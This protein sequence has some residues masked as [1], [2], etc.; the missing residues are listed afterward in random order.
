MVRSHAFGELDFGA[1]PSALKDGGWAPREVTIARR[2]FKLATLPTLAVVLCAVTGGVHRKRAHI[3]PERSA[4][5]AA[6]GPVRPLEARLAGASYAAYKTL[7]PD[8]AD[9][10]VISAQ[11]RKAG[12]KGSPEAVAD[13]GV[14]LLLKG[15]L[16]DSI[17]ALE[18]AVALDR[19]NARTES[20]LAA[21]YLARTPQVGFDDG[22]KALAHA[23]RAVHLDPSLPEA[24]FNHALALEGLSLLHDADASWRS[25]LQIDSTSSWAEEARLHGMGIA[26]A[27]A[28][29]EHR[30]DLLQLAATR[31]R[32]ALERAIVRDPQSAREFL[33]DE[34]LPQWA[35]LAEMKD[36]R[37]TP[38][39]A[40]MRELADILLQA[41]KDRLPIEAVEA[42]ERADNAASPGA[43]LQALA[44][45]HRQYS[46]GQSAL[47][48]GDI[49]KAAGLFAASRVAF[50]RGRSPFV[51]WAEFQ[52]GVCVYQ[53]ADYLGARA[54]LSPLLNAEPYPNLHA[55][56]LWILGLSEIVQ[57]DLD[58]SLSTYRRAL[59]LFRQS[60]ELRNAG[61]IENLIAEALR[62]LGRKDEA[63]RSLYAAVRA[64]AAMRDPRRRVAIL[65]E[66]ATTATAEGRPE[67][68]LLFHDEA[69]RGL[70]NGADRP[71]LVFALIKRAET[72][73]ALQR[74]AVAVADLEQARRILDHLTSD[75]VREA[76]IGDYLGHLGGILRAIDPERAVRSLSASAD[77]YRDSHYSLFL[78]ALLKERALS[79]EALGQQDLAERD[80]IEATEAAERALPTIEDDAAR[81]DYL[82]EITDLLD[83][84]V[85]LQLGRGRVEEAF[86]YEE[87]A[88]V[89]GLRPLKALTP[90]EIE[91]KLPQG[92]AVIG[93][94]AIRDL[95]LIWSVRRDGFAVA[96]SPLSV[97]DTAN[98]VARLRKAIGGEND[99]EFSTTSTALY[100]AIVGPV[101]GA[102]E[103]ATTIEFLPSQSLTKLPFVALQNPAT[104]HFLIEDHAVGIALSASSY[105]ASLANDRVKPRSKGDALVVGDPAFR[106]DLLQDLPRLP[107]AA[108][109]AK[110]I[111]ALY[112]KSTLLLGQQA[113]KKAFLAAAGQYEIV[114]FA[115]H[116]I[117]NLAAPLRSG[118]VFASSSREDTG[119]LTAA[120]LYDADFP[121]T[122][123]IVLSGCGTALGPIEESD[124]FADFAR[125]LFATGVPSVVASL[126]GVNDKESVDL[127]THFHARL[128]GGDDPLK[129]LRQAQLQMLGDLGRGATAVRRWAAFE[130]ISGGWSSGG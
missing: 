72:E 49:R 71:A 81:L 98:L 60:G 44:A 50:S 101:E 63:S 54:R 107:E 62:H 96:A 64:L 90:A 21:A 22:V 43:Q 2:V 109:E 61:A 102:L 92:V 16:D 70:A 126:W 79:Y 59:L 95:L 29:L 113:T 69:I 111:A 86:K 40:S 118:L 82:G 56:A 5:F 27:A 67:V 123:V 23:A 129:A 3:S 48:A 112:P 15:K 28:A 55:R 24:R 127:M 124:G 36:A 83:E 76:F 53:E 117:T 7:P 114:H 8:L 58:A 12:E 115:G 84:M 41:E 34:A 1:I 30:P 68:A 93:Y 35:R 106:T 88:R 47:Q 13:L 51:R 121:R 52:L 75:G 91:R 42:I 39:L 37:T 6:T 20:D 100:R 33:E 45:G 25:Y 65:A 97:R 122:R 94:T 10:V 128:Q 120:D 99:A 14:A 87:R 74:I 4:I 116:N 105:I 119:V 46:E 18:R 108:R 103:S 110:R 57:N 73:V 77:F 11:L 85:L 104:G 19:R 130:L 26:R 32:G 80:L 78:P 9:R 31:D 17:S 125:P 89:Q 66:A 38:L